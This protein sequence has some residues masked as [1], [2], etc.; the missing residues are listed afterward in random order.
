MENLLKATIDIMTKNKKTQSNIVHI[1]SPD[2]KYV[3]DW[4]QFQK[5]ADKN[6]NNQTMKFKVTYDL[7]ILFDDN[8]WLEREHDVGLEFWRYHSIPKAGNSK[9]RKIKDIWRDDQT[10]ETIYNIGKS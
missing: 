8:S 2:G 4:S 5:L 9:S 7:I 1:G 6:Y 10:I 3:M